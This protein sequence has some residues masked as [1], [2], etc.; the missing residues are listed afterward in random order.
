[1]S[2][3][4]KVK[5]ME[6]VRDTKNNSLIN[7]NKYELENYLSKRKSLIEQ[8]E[9]INSIKADVSSLKDDMGQIKGLLLQLIQD[10]K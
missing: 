1:M 2:E 9:E 6:M 7:Q 10:K 5:G 3:Y 8:K 4:I